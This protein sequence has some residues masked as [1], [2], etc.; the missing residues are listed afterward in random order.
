M[1]GS[2][3]LSAVTARLSV[4]YLRLPQAVNLVDE[5]VDKHK[6]PLQCKGTHIR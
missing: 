4:T 6:I 3:D 1:K 5:N 2:L